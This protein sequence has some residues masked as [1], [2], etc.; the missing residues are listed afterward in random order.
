MFLN[1]EIK[2]IDSNYFALQDSNPLV[3][4]LVEHILFATN[5][6][7]FDQINKTIALSDKKTR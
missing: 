3:V 4:R 7:R 5:R 1:R 6:T 2:P